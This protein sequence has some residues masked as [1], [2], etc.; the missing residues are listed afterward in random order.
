MDLLQVFWVAMCFG[1]LLASRRGVLAGGLCKRTDALQCLSKI[2]SVVSLGI[3]SCFLLWGNC[4]TLRS[5]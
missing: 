5:P 3:I 4:E 2:A 1:F